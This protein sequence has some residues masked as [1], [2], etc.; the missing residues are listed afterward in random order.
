MSPSWIP[1]GPHPPLPY[2]QSPGASAQPPPSC[3]HP[4]HL[5]HLSQQPQAPLLPLDQQGDPYTQHS[6]LAPEVPDM[7]PRP[8][9]APSLVVQLLWTSG[10]GLWASGRSS[11]KVASGPLPLPPATNKSFPFPEA[12]T[13]KCLSPVPVGPGHPSLGLPQSLGPLAIAPPA[14]LANHP[15]TSTQ[16]QGC[17]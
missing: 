8:K 9:P 7:A 11:A 12:L 4:G 5:P 16:T 3:P 2:L 13:A 14:A 15:S 1:P 6:S 10:R 17:I